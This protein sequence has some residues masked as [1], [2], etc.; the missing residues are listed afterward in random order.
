MIGETPAGW[1]GIR[2]RL[3]ME[4]KKIEGELASF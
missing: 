3:R 2:I 4:D 1:A